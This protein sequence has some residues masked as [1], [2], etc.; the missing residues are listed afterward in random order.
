MRLNPLRAA[1]LGSAVFLLSIGALPSA[2][3]SGANVDARGAQIQDQKPFDGTSE[4][5]LSPLRELLELDLPAQAVELFGKRVAPGG[6]LFLRGDARALVARALFALGRKGAAQELVRGDEPGLKNE[7]A[8]VVA[9]AW[10]AM[11]QDQLDLALRELLRSENGRTVPRYPNDGDATILLARVFTRRGD[12]LSA[13]APASRFL[14]RFR[15]HAETHTALHILGQAA[16]ERGDPDRAREL[17]RQRDAAR[18]WQE[19]YRVRRLQARRAPED[20]LPRLGLALLWMEIEEWL[21]AQTVLEDLLQKWPRE[22]SAWFHLA[23]CRRTLGSAS[24]ALMAYERA[25]ALEPKHAP[26]IA[27]RALLLISLGRLRE[28]QEALEKLLGSA[29]GADPN[30]APAQLALARLLVE[31]EGEEAAAARYA[32]YLELGGRE[33]LSPR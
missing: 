31:S 9:R 17:F 23:E 20:P 7:R 25:I 22:G 24:L 15:L 21:R 4:D 27:N 6:D 12:F 16:V 1:A 13:E 3:E 32:I 8:L 11:E 18:Q 5:G 14:A 10:L 19:L 33:P 30:F 29:A 26:A 28:A 2:Q